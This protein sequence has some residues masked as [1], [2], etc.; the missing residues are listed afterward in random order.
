MSNDAS[1][2]GLPRADAGTVALWGILLLLLLAALYFAR[3]LVLP[4]AFAVLAS[5][6]LAP[7][8]RIFL[9]MRVPAPLVAAGLLFCLLGGTGYGVAA[10]SAPA[11]D[12]IQRAPDGAREVERKLRFL[13][14]P[15]ERV[16]RA[17]AQ[18]ERA[19]RLPGPEEQTV[20]VQPRRLTDVL[21]EQTQGFLTGMLVAAVLLFFLLSS[22]DGFLEK[23]VEIAPR[24][25][26]KKR[27]VSAAREI[28]TEVSTYLLTMT[29]INAVFG[30]LVG[31]AMWALGVPNAALWGVVAGLTNFIPYIGA[32]ALTF[33]LA[34]VGVLS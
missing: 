10:L 34:G 3:S 20:V 16:S 31:L 4:M 8:V 25:Q 14:D 22:P 15:V 2:E 19:A 7:V 23:A 32:L 12:W 17:T 29:A 30:T 21:F 1:P 26:D 13:R 33:V 9:R 5:L 11:A 18:V 27:I 28:E 6:V 24:L